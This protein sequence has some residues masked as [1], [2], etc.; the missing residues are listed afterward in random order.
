M[1]LKTFH[2]IPTI[3]NSFCEDSVTPIQKPDKETTKKEK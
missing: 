2:K 3:P 1:L